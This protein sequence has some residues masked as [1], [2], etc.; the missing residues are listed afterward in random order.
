MCCIIEREREEGGTCG[1]VSYSMLSIATI[2]PLIM[3]VSPL[4]LLAGESGLGKSTLVRSLFLT[5]LFGTKNCPPALGRCGQYIP[6]T[7]K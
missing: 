7:G 2:M 6:P 3:L 5:N 1:V 4:S